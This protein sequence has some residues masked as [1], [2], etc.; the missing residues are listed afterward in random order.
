MGSPIPLSWRQAAASLSAQYQDG[1]GHSLWWEDV[2]HMEK[3]ISPDPGALRHS[4]Q[5]LLGM[6]GQRPEE[7]CSSLSEDFQVRPSE[8]GQEAARL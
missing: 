7:S 2:Q 4:P 5:S 1:F 8:I 6:K 3:G